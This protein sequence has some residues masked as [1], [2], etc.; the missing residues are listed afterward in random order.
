MA[1]A[2]Q[3]RVPP[4]MRQ[5]AADSRVREH[6]LPRRPLHNLAPRMASQ[7]IR[8]HGRE[9]DRLVSP[10]G[11]WLLMNYYIYMYMKFPREKKNKNEQS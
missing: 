3:R 8:E 10:L 11:L 5:E 6:F 2:L 9:L 7:E 1:D 4:A